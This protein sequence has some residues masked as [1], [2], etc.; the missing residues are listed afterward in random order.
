MTNGIRIYSCYWSPN[1]TLQDYLDFLARLQESIKTAKTQVLVTGDFNAHH[2]DWGSK[3]CNKR[4]EALSDLI[5]GLG[6]VVSNEGNTPT[7]RNQNGTSIIYITI[8]TPTLATK[9]ADWKVLDTI[10]LSDHS[11]ILY[12]ISTVLPGKIEKT[13]NSR[14][15]NHRRLEDVLTTKKPN[16][17]RT[18]N[19]SPEDCAI[20]LTT[21]IQDTSKKITPP[22]PANN[23]RKTVY[24]LNP[25]ISSARK[26]ANHLRRVYQRKLK[27]SGPDSCQNEKAEAKSG[28]LNLVELIRT[29]YDEMWKK[30]CDEV[31]KDPWGRPYKLVMGKL[32]RTPPIPG[33]NTPGR[34]DTIVRELF[35][36]QQLIRLNKPPPI[37]PQVV[38]EIA[39]KMDE[40]VTAT[41]T[42]K[43]NTASGPDGITNEVLKCFAERQPDVLLKTYNKCLTEGHFPTFW[44]RARLVLLRK[45]DKPLDTPSSY[46]PLCMLDCPG[47]RAFLEE[48][49]CLSQRQFGFRKGRSTTDAVHTLR[50]IVETNRPK[51][52]IGVMTL[53]IKNSFNENHTRKAYSKIPP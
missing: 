22:T 27:R 42:L 3:T 44:K 18:E 7:F 47:K 46:H 10:S 29:A 43:K 15:T 50:T 28:K 16:I 21:Y 38:K 23:R 45:G 1:S 53:D 31:E 12:M 13:W 48:N 26:A 36:Q 52:K 34:I 6:L 25:E 19:I 11:Y 14:K 8:A 49:N 37:H 24:W 35:P 41:K 30:L 17:P 51:N 4:G 9:I 20:N 2:T 40:L 5:S 33:L 32:A 39:I